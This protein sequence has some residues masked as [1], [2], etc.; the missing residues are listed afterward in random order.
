MQYYDERKN[1]FKSTHDDESNSVFPYNMFKNLIV[2]DSRAFN[3]DFSK[4]IDASS[5]DEGTLRPL[6]IL[7]SKDNRLKVYTWDEHGGSMT[8]YS[9]ITSISD[10]KGVI[11]YATHMDESEGF[12]VAL[13]GQFDLASGTYRID[14]IMNS[15]AE[16]IYLVYKHYSGSTLMQFQEVTAYNI[17]DNRIL[18]LKIFDGEM[19]LSV[20]F[21]PTYNGHLHFIYEKNKFTVPETR[22]NGLNPYAGNLFTGRTLLYKWNGSSFEYKGITYEKNDDLIDCLKNFKYNVALGIIGN[23]RIRIDKMPDNSYR[24][25]SWRLPK[26]CLESPDIIINNGYEDIESLES[27]EYVKNIKYVFHNKGY[28]YIV[29][30]R[31]QYGNFSDEHLVVKHKDKVILSK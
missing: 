28:F 17:Y 1:E 24:Y 2:N 15:T 31:S 10:K 6:R 14:T 11:S 19:D 4:I 9:G 22:E 18:P 5:K 13:E 26:K 30:W 8:N 25:T 27:D 21:A 29:S 3:Y 20:Y 7:K 12:N 16:T 23:Y